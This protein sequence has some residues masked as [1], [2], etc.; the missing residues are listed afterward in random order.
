ME[1]RET[2]DGDRNLL[3]GEAGVVCQRTADEDGCDH[4]HART[5]VGGA[6]ASLPARLRPA[7]SDRRLYYAVTQTT[8]TRT[9]VSKSPGIFL[10]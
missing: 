7:T 4:A 1:G 10:P 3:T 6:G 8:L 5:N 2:V 9:P